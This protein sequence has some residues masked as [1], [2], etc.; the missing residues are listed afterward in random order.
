MFFCINEEPHLT[1]SI[2]GR[3]YSLS[4]CMS[5][6][7]PDYVML[8]W[9]TYRNPRYDRVLRLQCYSQVSC[10]GR[11]D[12][13]SLFLLCNI[14]WV[15]FGIWDSWLLNRIKRYSVF[16]LPTI[17]ESMEHTTK[18]SW[19]VSILRHTFSIWLYALP[20]WWS[21]S[22]VKSFDKLRSYRIFCERARLLQGNHPW[23]WSHTL[24]I[25]RTVWT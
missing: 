15:T 16:G 21:S 3:G 25:R 18:V 9:W 1:V 14:L 5:L 23:R 11:N 7:T 17:T 8:I 24:G 10:M 12:I 6:E 2:R 22:R 13:P 19:Y 20:C 4:C